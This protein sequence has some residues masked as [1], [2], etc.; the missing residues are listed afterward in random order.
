MIGYILKKLI[1][2]TNLFI[3][4]LSLTIFVFFSN[5]TNISTSILSA[6]PESENKELIKKFEKTNNTK[7]LM[8]SVKGF[9]KKSLEKI[10]NIESKINQI[11]NIELKTNIKNK[12]LQNHIKEYDFFF[13]ELNNNKIK[14]IDLQKELSDI[15]NNLKTSFIPIYI[16][17]NDPLD[18]Y[19]NLKKEQKSIN[20][21]LILGEYGYLSYFHI[22][23]NDLDSYNKIYHQI[24]NLLSIYSDTKVFSPIFYYVENSS[25]IKSEANNIIILALLLLI[26]LYIFILKNIKLLI[27]TLFTLTSSSIIAITILTNL[28]NE[29][30]IFVLV[31]G[32]CISTVSIDYMFHHYLHNYYDNQKNTFNKEVFFGFL[33]TISI[34]IIFSFTN[35]PLITQLALFSIISLSSSYFIFAFLYPYLNFKKKNPLWIK[36]KI[37]LPKIEHKKWFLFSIIII[38]LSSTWLNFD[39]DLRK[40]DYKNLTLEKDEKFFMNKLLNEK[41]LINIIIEAKDIDTLIKRSKKIKSLS[42]FTMIP[43]TNLLDKTSYNTK[44]EDYKNILILKELIIK[45]AK[46]IGFRADYFKDSYNFNLNMPNYSLKKLKLYGIEIFK[47]NDKYITYGS[48]DL[49][50]FQK[51]SKLPYIKS[52]S[53]KSLFEETM[54]NLV[55]Q[56]ILL[57][58]ISITLIILLIVIITK[59]KKIQ[60]LLFLTFPLSIFLIYGFFYSLN[61]LHIFMIFVI[62]AISIDYAFYTS[63]KMDINTKK[64][65]SYSLLSTFA[66]FG[67]LIFTDINSLFSIGIIA[68]IGILSISILLIFLK[69]QKNEI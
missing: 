12:Q 35:F 2:L 30:S 19:K 18:L 61:I 36:S 55:N 43:M 46:N 65:I 59:E 37:Y 11:K 15:Y 32:I 42:K 34:F 17:K 33:T 31:F 7:I 40:L 69:V 60:S 38:I 10:K 9:D 63:I 52:L 53:I 3:L 58:L 8:V 20:N 62:L 29:V 51:I 57:G 14:S 28:Y 22:K 54:L 67:V 50:S 24:N 23:A 64:A 45:E 26:T 39:F 13:K 25:M 6:L 56:L 47:H 4:L 5:Y 21:R 16:N 27:N 41:K 66:G 48:V 44:L 68:T 49:I 1:N